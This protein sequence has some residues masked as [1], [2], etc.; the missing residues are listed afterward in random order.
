MIGENG[1]VDIIRDAESR[2]YVT[3]LDKVPPWLGRKD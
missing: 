2:D 3:Q 1:E